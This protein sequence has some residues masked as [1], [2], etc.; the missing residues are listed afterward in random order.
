METKDKGTV[1]IEKGN[2]KQITCHKFTCKELNRELMVHENVDCK[3]HTSVSDYKTGYRL[4]GL[5]QTVSS[6]KSSE[7]EEA[8]KAFINRYTKE[9]IAEE[10]QRIE[11]IQQTQTKKD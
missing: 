1:T 9:G 4:F 7:V 3:N 2:K 11:N 10:F 8:L 5:P 6:V